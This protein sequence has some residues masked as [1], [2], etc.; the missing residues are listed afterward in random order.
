[1]KLRTSNIF[2][3]IERNP[4]YRFLSPFPCFA[5]GNDGEGGGGNEPDPPKD[6]DGAE[7]DPPEDKA[8][9]YDRFKKVNEDRK[10]AEKELAELKAA[11]AKAEQ[12]KLAEEKKFKELAEAKIKEA[13]EAAK[14]KADAE[15][16]LK[17]TLI[18]SALRMAAL[19]AG[20][21]KD[22][23]PYVLKAVEREAIEVG[24]EGDVTGADKAIEALKKAIPA[25]F[26]ESGGGQPGPSGSPKGKSGMKTSAELAKEIREKRAKNT[27]KPDP[28]KPG[29]W[30]KI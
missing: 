12:D 7:P 2:G 30:G 8:I 5:E 20:A 16:R 11:Q 1:M 4:F 26:S 3:D 22:Q 18:E 17:S 14:A 27:P 15:S 29:P 9:P 24:D 19:E 6:G 28:D 10:K 21:S 25:M 23:L 13:E